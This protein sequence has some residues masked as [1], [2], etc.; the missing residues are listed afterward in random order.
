MGCMPGGR[1][2][3]IDAAGQ[4]TGHGAPLRKRCAKPCLLNKISGLGENARGNQRES[5][6]EQRRLVAV[7]R[8]KRGRGE[9]GLA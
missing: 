5:V 3:E 9:M 6:A 1:S 7:R 8:Q 2:S 4:A